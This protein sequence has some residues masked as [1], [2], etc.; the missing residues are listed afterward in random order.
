MKKTLILLLLL[1]SYNSKSQ[2]KTVDEID[3]FTKERII[4]VNVSNSKNWRQNDNISEGIFNNIFLNFKM[5]DGSFYL[6]FGVQCNDVLSCINEN[7]KTILLLD[8]NETIELTNKSNND[9]SYT[10]VSG[11]YGITLAD[12]KKLTEKN[13]QEF[14]IYYSEGYRDYKVTSNRKDIIKKAAE[15]F[16]TSTQK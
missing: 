3:K 16:I 6:Q 1:T 13:L 12:L 5:V 8:G 15:L 4:Q 2:T 14:R 10:L 11:R 9:C 7:S